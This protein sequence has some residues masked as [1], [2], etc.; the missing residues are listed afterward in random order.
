MKRTN[1][2]KLKKITGGVSGWAVLAVSTAITF[3]AG[4]IEGYFYPKSCPGE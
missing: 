2:E 3:L 4:I 1:N